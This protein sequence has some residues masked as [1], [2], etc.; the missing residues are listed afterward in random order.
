MYAIGHAATGKAARR[1]DGRRSAIGDS[2]ERIKSLYPNRVAVSPH[3]YTD[4][5]YLTVTPAEKADSAYRIIFE[6]DGKKVVHYRAG[7][8]PQVEYVEGCS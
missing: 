2:E 5:H 4:G 1:N 6:T 7:V 3:K 8:R